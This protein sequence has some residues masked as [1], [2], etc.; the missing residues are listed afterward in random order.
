MLHITQKHTGKMEGM[1]SLSTSTLVN[2]YC[3]KRAEVKG[4]ICSHC[5]AQRMTKAYKALNTRLEENTLELTTAIIPIKQLPNINASYFRL[6]AFGD[7]NNEAQVINYFNL[8][9]KNGRTQFAPWTKHAFIIKNAIRHGAIKPDNLIIIASSP[10]IDIPLDIDALHAHGFDFIDKV[11]TV[12]SKGTKATINCGSRK[13]IECL[14]CYTKDTSE[15][16]RELL[17]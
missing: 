6:E 7:I 1:Q 8:C 16:V 11:F 4:S 3:I 15:Y 17:K 2:P 9:N 12:Y 10:M 14:R 13:C 5:Y